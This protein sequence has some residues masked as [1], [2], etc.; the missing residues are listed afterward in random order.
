MVER[1]PAGVRGAGRAVRR[2]AAATG[3]WTGCS[4]RAAGWRARRTIRPAGSCCSATSPTTG[5]CATTRSAGGSTTFASPAGFTNGRTVDRQGRFVACE[6]GNRRVTR[7][8]H[9][10]SHPVL[11][12]AYEGHR[13][14]SPNDVVVARRRRRSGSP[15]R[16]YGIRTDY[17]G[18]GRRRRSAPT[19]STGW[20]PTR[21]AH[22]VLHR[23]RPT[24]RA[25]LRADSSGCSW[26]T[27]SCTTS[28]SSTSI[29]RRLTG[30]RCSPPTTRATTASGSTTAAGCGGR[31]TTAC[32]A[33]S[34]TA[35]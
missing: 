35:P 26:S 3:A 31:P 21:R 32:T 34:R 2:H 22:A 8:E 27:A 6:H 23:L 16:R 25:G 28:G 12:D 30:G 5:C 24:Q 20:I 1:M 11:A 14:N 15:T 4:P 10:G 29:E 9:D 17:E 7:V 18:T 19:T 13:L 33:T